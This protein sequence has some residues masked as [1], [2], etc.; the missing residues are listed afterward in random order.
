MH[1]GEKNIFM[2]IIENESGLLILGFFRNNVCVCF[3]VFFVYIS[4][5]ECA[6]AIQSFSL[7]SA[8]IF[9]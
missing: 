6:H 7:S 1:C 2:R 5:Q 9:R 4:P 8:V 3:F